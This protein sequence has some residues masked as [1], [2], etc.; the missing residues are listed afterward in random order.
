MGICVVYFVLRLLYNLMRTELTHYINLK[1]FYTMPAK[2]HTQIHTHT[3]VFLAPFKGAQVPGQLL[4]CVGR[5]SPLKIKYI[6]I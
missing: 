4:H 5:R 3:S 2:Q 6:H 1:L